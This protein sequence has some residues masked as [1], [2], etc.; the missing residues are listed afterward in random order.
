[1]MGTGLAGV[2]F[3]SKAADLLERV[4]V[5]GASLG[6]AV[7]VAV[8][9]AGSLPGAWGAAATRRL[10]FRAGDPLELLALGTRRVDQSDWPDG[11]CLDLASALL[12]QV[13]TGG[14]AVPAARQ[15]DGS[16]GPE[17]VV[18]L[19]RQ[20]ALSAVLAARGSGGGGEGLCLALGI[21]GRHLDVA[22]VRLRPG[23]PF[24]A[25]GPPGSGRTTALATVAASARTAGCEV[26]T[27][28]GLADRLEQRA[29]AT[30]APPPLVVIVD[31]ADRVPDHDGLLARLAAGSVPGVHVVASASADAVRGAFGHWTSELR[32]AGAGLVLR[33]RSDLDADLLGIPLLPRW[34][35]PLGAPG[36]GVL[37]VDGEAAPVQVAMS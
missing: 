14:W 5:D 22:M 21:D 11:R 3:G 20:I 18:A 35:V 8:D 7:A 27:A 15:D 32:R 30:V 23:Q 12:A 9:R 25:Y 6:L 19:P 2:L 24:V 16:P 4:V 34:A 10:A 1:M 26:A 28:E 37:V 36:R 13:A 29:A 17:P 33:P 31:D